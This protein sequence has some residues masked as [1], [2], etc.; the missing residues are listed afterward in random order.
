MNCS[1]EGCDGAVLA[2]GLCSRHYK[3]WQRRGRPPGPDLAERT[4]GGCSVD[5][6]SRLSY[7][8]G[9]CERH[10]RQVRRTGG[11]LSDR[12]AQA[13]SV[14]DCGKAAEAHG[15]CHGHYLR[16]LRTGDLTP[17]Q[18]LRRPERGQCT[19]SDCTRPHQAQGYCLAHYQ[20]F[21]STGTAAEATPLREVAGQGFLHRGYRVVPVPPEDRWLTNGVTP[22]AEHRL[23]MA[24][25][26]GRPLEPDE[27]VHHRS[28]QRDDNRIEN[29]ELWSRYQPSG[30]RVVDKIEWALALL[31]MY[32]P[33]ALVQEKSLDVGDVEAIS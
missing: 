30:Q 15:W 29:L 20:R 6:C 23:I 25:F 16:W 17:G 18:P 33:Y 12:S 8:R 5:D 26:L 21:R 24:R 14:A 10:Y 7:A 27:S 9:L 31:Q 19:V 28:G 13:C 32:A 1:E 11:V 4:A 22:F 2:R 3:A